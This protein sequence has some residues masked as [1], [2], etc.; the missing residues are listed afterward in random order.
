M[1]Q[2]VAFKTLD[3]LT[4]RGWFYAPQ[5]APAPWP[6]VVMAHGFSAVKEMYL[7]AYAEVF[8][9]AG[10]AVLVYDNR[11]LG[12]SDGLPRQEIDRTLQVRDYQDAITYAESLPGVD[13]ERIG[14]WGSSFSGGHVLMVGAL[15]RRVKCV[16]SQVPATDT[17]DTLRLRPPGQAARMREERRRRLAG[18]KPAM[19][20]VVSDDP[21]TPCVLPTADSWRWFTETARRRAPAWRNEVTVL[22]HDLSS[23]VH[24]GDYAPYIAPTPLLML[25]AEDDALTPAA[26]AIAVFHRAREPK[27]LQMLKG[28]HFEPYVEGFET[29]SAAARD[30]FVQH[31]CGRQGLAPPPAP[32][33]RAA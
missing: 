29:S 31:L 11:N 13:P 6:V 19:V 17:L 12:A 7:D 24:A 4:L 2:D 21:A 33:R 22:S 15:D 9:A 10:L 18:E 28:G 3:G 20:A 30:W 27:R 23:M 8:A 1:R 16:V 32:A 5:T 25:V 14:I 26:P